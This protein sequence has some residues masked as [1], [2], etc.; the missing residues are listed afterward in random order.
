[1][2]TDGVKKMK[3]PID[4]K[5]KVSWM[6]REAAVAFGLDPDR[7]PGFVYGGSEGP[8]MRNFG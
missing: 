1:M 7:N 3:K 2:A 5:K 4:F 6:S 8:Y